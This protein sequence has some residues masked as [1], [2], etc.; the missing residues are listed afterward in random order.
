M[1]TLL[2]DK[3]FK[4]IADGAKQIAKTVAKTMTDDVR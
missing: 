1:E 3:R 4:A 2:A